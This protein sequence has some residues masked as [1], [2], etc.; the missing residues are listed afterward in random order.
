MTTAADLREKQ[1]PLRQR[2]RED[3]TA[4]LVTLTTTAAVQN[5]ASAGASG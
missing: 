5:A 1:G 4:A 3:P 2:Y